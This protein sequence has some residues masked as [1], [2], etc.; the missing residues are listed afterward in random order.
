[1][2]YL[3]SINF[4]YAHQHGFRKLLSCETQLSEFTDD[5]L[6]HMDDHLQIDAI[7]L[8]F[9][10]AFDRVPHNYLL[11]KLATLGIPPTLI[12]WIEHFLKG[13]VQYTTAN[14]HEWFA[15]F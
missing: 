4:F 14:S 11:A 5:I 9:S 2:N 1:M 8:D 10:K 12:T 7:F 3:E 13:R 6:Q 15:N